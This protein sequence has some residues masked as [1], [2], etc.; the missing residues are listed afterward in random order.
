MNDSKNKPDQTWRSEIE[1]IEYRK[2]L[3]A[4]MGGPENLERQRVAGRLNVR[5][6][7]ELILDKDSFHETGAITGV[8]F[9]EGGKLVRMQPSNCVIGTGTGGL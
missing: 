9:F 7:L 4:Q 2:S 5:Q 6:R 1:E 8:P 3:T